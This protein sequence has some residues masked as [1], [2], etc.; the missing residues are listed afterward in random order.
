MIREMQPVQ[1]VRMIFLKQ[2]F[3]DLTI[4]GRCFQIQS[5]FVLFVSSGR[6]SG[7]LRFAEPCFYDQW[8][9]KWNQTWR[10]LSL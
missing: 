5:D 10:F 6:T 8:A 9:L 7:S 2:S 3:R 1:I 4:S